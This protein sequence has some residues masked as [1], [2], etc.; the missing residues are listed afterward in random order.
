MPSSPATCSPPAAPRP[1]PPDHRGLLPSQ[2]PAPSPPRS[3]QLTLKPLQC[4][5]S[6]LPL[7]RVTTSNANTRSAA[8]AA[9][10][11]VC[12]FFS[13]PAIRVIR[14]WP[15]LDPRRRACHRGL[16]EEEEYRAHAVTVGGHG[17]TSPTSTRT[18]CYEWWE[19]GQN[20]RTRRR[21]EGVAG[22]SGSHTP[23]RSMRPD[24]PP[25]AS[26]RRRGRRA[27]TQAHVAA[28]F[29]SIIRAAG[30]PAPSQR[31]H[32]E[33]NRRRNRFRF[34]GAGRAAPNVATKDPGSGRRA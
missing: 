18:S 19:G 2:R 29:N 6:R 17:S 20:I 12:S 34:F 16:G 27:R 10:G 7:H 15:S 8:R 9:D 11:R 3:E 31:P 4:R 32:H 1:S 28:S 14:G 13:A 5:C 30:G 26:R 22:G 21:G 24:P 25:P 23:A 33:R